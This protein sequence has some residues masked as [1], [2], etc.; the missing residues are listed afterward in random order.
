MY[1]VDFS[2]SGGHLVHRLRGHDD[3]VLSLSWCPVPG[4][5]FL[6]ESEDGTNTLAGQCISSFAVP[7][8]CGHAAWG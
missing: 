8:Y 4:E 6:K 5:T 2:S 3:E 1:L 7:C